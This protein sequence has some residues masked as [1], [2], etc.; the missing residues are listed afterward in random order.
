[1]PAAEPRSAWRDR[2]TLLAVAV[3]ALAL[4]VVAYARFCEVHR[5]LWTVGLHDRNAHY[6]FALRMAADVRQGQLLRLLVDLDSARVWPPLHGVLAAAVLAS[7]GL[8]DRLAVLPSLVGWVG[9]AVFAFLTARRAVPRGGNLA[10]TVA[11]LFVLASPAHR[12]YATDVMLESLGACLTAA[13]LYAYLVAKQSD[14]TSPWPGRWLGLALTALFLEKYNYW[15]LVVFALAAAEWTA[16]P[17]AAWAA[18]RS[19]LAG[20]AWRRALLNELKRP[21]N[22]MLAALLGV[23]AAVRAHGDRPWVFGGTE[24]SLYPPHNVVQVAYVVVFLRLWAWWRAG[25]RDVAGPFVGTLRPVIRWHLVP[26]AVWLLLPKRAS[27]FLWY[28]GPNN[29]GDDQHSDFVAG[30][31]AYGREV[32]SEYHAGVAAAILAGVLF[33]AALAGARRLRP[34]A[35]AVLWLVVIAAVLTVGHPNRKGRFVHSWLPAVWV[36]AG[37]GFALLTHGRATARATR[38]RPLLAGA[39]AVGVG[40]VLLPGLLAPGHAPEGGPHPQTA[41]L[42]DLSDAYLDELDGPRRAAVL[43][44]VPVRPMTQWTYLQRHGSFDGFEDVWYDFGSPGDANR[45]GFLSWLETTPCDTLVYL[46]RGPGLRDWGPDAVGCAGH[47]ELLDLVLTQE[48]F[49]VVRRRELPAHCCTV[50]V[51][52]REAAAG[53]GSAHGARASR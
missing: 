45:R 53:G 37:A 51:L 22:F 28:L 43:A 24:V 47:A 29:G 26:V 7:G 15:L 21:S 31:L 6:L 4:A 17:G 8:D 48:R 52:R 41:S 44:A 32:L 9:A 5:H 42:L 2:L 34:G 30:V 19:A 14:G 10:G 38:L 18:A 25:G 27:F 40:A 39:A 46:G 49:R 35:A 50:L 20:V 1:V 23:V 3:V 11:A 12:A 16:R 13:A 36:A 33:L